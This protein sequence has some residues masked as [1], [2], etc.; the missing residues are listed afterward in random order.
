MRLPD[1]LPTH[2]RVAADPREDRTD[3][4]PHMPLGVTEAAW[5]P[6]QPAQ[7]VGLPASS[8]R[9]ATKRHTRSVISSCA[10]LL[11]QRARRKPGRLAPWERGCYTSTAGRRRR[12]A[13]RV[14]AVATRGRPLLRG[15]HHTDH[16]PSRASAS[17]DF[18]HSARDEERGARYVAGGSEARRPEAPD[19]RAEHGDGGGHEVLVRL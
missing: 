12:S 17:R 19:F 8:R 15:A 6:R 13:A 7:V 11:P 10:S 9:S 5:P 2:P 14:R 4:Q 3:V 18:Q 1:A 16:G